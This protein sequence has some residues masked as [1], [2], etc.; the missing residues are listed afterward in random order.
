MDVGQDSTVG[1]ATHYGLDGPGIESQ[2]GPDFPHQSRPVLGTTLPP[3]Q[4]YRVIPG[5]KQPG[6]GI[7]HPPP[8]S[9]EVKE[10]VELYLYSASRPL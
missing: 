1:M 10:K 2:W 9:A 6:R 4:W 5:V 3:I 7:D 8:Y